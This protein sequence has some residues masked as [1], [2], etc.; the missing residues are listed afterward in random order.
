MYI[1]I[2]LQEYYITI[3]REK[4]HHVCLQWSLDMKKHISS[5]FLRVWEWYS[6]LWV[7]ERVLCL[8]RFP[9]SIERIQFDPRIW[10]GSVVG[11][12]VQWFG[13]DIGIVHPPWLCIERPSIPWLRIRQDPV[14]IPGAGVIG[15][16]ASSRGGGQTHQPMRGWIQEVVVVFIV[17]AL[18]NVPLGVQLPLS[19]MRPSLLRWRSQAPSLPH[20]ASGG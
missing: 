13:F 9:Q 14:G 17:L 18:Q 3:I 6:H 12:F 7:R 16:S 15:W 4:L 19:V 11:S 8:L 10:T 20:L 1:L 2:K 5:H